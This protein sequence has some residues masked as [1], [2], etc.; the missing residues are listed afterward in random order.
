MTDS[1]RR[2]GEYPQENSPAPHAPFGEDRRHGRDGLAQGA[3]AG[4]Y[5][6]P[7]PYPP[8]APGRPEA[9]RPPVIR[10]ETVPAGAGDAG[11]FGGGGFQGGGYEGGGPHR[12]A[13]AATPAP[14]AKR[15]VALLAA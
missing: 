4:A 15:P 10:G 2:E 9:H 13:H 3:G 1:F 12:P 7:P 5:P 8:T 11:G 6:P 14:R